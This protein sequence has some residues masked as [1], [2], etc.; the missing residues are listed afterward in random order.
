M[1]VGGINEPNEDRIDIYLDKDAPSTLTIPLRVDDKAN[2][3]VHAST[4]NI[5]SG[6]ITL[7][8]NYSEWVGA[9]RVFRDARKISYEILN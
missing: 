9:L 6:T 8:D 1:F 5:T 7:Y 3:H 2:I 4:G